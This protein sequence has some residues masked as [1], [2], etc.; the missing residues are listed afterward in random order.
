MIYFV[1]RCGREE[2]VV[3]RRLQSILESQPVRNVRHAGTENPVAE[4][5]RNLG[6]ADEFD[7]DDLLMLC[8]SIARVC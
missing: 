4:I 3:L 1:G 2:M 7:R 8:R 5:I 6:R